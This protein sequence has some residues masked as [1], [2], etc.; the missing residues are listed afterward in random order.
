MKKQKIY[1][2]IIFSFSLLFSSCV[3][4]FAPTSK[5]QVQTSA[6]YNFSIVE[7]NK[8]FSEYLK[9][10]KLIEKINTD[11]KILDL[12]DY[13]P[14]GNQ[15]I[16]SYVLR[17][18]FQEI[19]LDFGTYLASLD[20]GKNIEAM[21]FEQEVQIPSVN[22][23][24]EKDI[25]LSIIN[26]MLVSAVT[27]TGTT[28]G[29]A[30]AQKVNFTNF[31]TITI[32]SGD[33]TLFSTATGD[34]EL[35]SKE[36]LTQASVGAE[37]ILATGT[38][39]SGQVSF[40]L[41]GKTLY[42]DNTF[43]V[44]KDADAGYAFNAMLSP[45]AKVS[46]ATGVTQSTGDIELPLIQI[47]IYNASNPL[48]SC[49]FGTGSSINFDLE[50][51]CLDSNATL[52]K[53]VKLTGGLDLELNGTTSLVGKQFLNQ[54]INAQIT[55]NL[56]F[57]NASIDLTKPNP[58][59]KITSTIG[60]I[61]EAKVKVPEDLITNIS[62]NIL[63]PSAAT[64]VIKAINWEAGCG[65][66][67]KY[68]NTFPTGNDF[69]LTNV[70]STFLGLSSCNATI[71]S[72]QTTQ[73]TIDTLITSS[74]QTTDIALDNDVDFNANLVLP[75]YDSIEKTF[76]VSNVEPGQ[77]Y[78]INLSIEP[79]FDWKSIVISMSHLTGLSGSTPM[80]LNPKALLSSLEESMNLSGSESLSD[81]LKLSSLK[82]HLFCE[83]PNISLFD[84]S[85]FSGIV[86]FSVGSGGTG[87]ETYLLGTSGSPESMP[88]VSEPT[89]QKNSNGTIISTISGGLSKDISSL[90]NNM[91][92]DDKI[93]LDY[94]LSLATGP[95]GEVTIKKED[96]KN[97]T[98]TSMKIVADIILP[99]EF[100]LENSGNAY[101]LDV[102]KIAKKEYAAGDS[103]FFGRASATELGD[104]LQKFLGLIENVSVN[105]DC[106]SLPLKTSSAMK[107]AIDLDGKNP[108][109]GASSFD[110]QI[111]SFNGGSFVEG[112]TKILESLVYPSA[113]IVIPEG[114]ISVPRKLVFNSKVGLTINCSGKPVTVVGD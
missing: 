30:T 23:N 41:S 79:V 95:S 35:H 17:M 9:P 3:Q 60:T 84:D 51:P 103:D 93:T 112:P 10:S 68:I 26:T 4:S 82:I 32:N 39:S 97:A 114:K 21:N 27:I 36:G 25:E 20:I 24:Q 19:P 111:L 8:D 102:M 11:G 37:S 73:T 74:E 101:S 100:K 109:G 13:N 54:D 91:G 58:K 16:Q 90:I 38:M 89:I 67:I 2:A 7:I 88:F 5:I 78:K 1:N 69:N 62:Q 49:T 61:S 86:K 87:K 15:T 53:S 33:L 96:L 98:N 83:K 22:L 12:C 65:L 104:T 47:P 42:G 28:T 55:L 92:S 45:T 66:M 43:I 29:G 113:N 18:P 75:G 64:Q 6:K 77:T 40:N 72:N 107:F 105:Y 63:L 106:S 44:F 76:V 85:S 14:G 94:S 59:V 48:I 70:S 31:K 110:E 80:E 71:Q 56:D 108:N 46:Y 52:N 34:V 50:A 99:L 57:N 81:K